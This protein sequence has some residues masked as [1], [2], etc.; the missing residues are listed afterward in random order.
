MHENVSNLLIETGNII[1]K[2]LLL[3][4]FSNLFSPKQLWKNSHITIVSLKP[5]RG[6]VNTYLA[7]TIHLL[8][9]LYPLSSIVQQASLSYH[10]RSFVL[11]THISQSDENNK[12]S[13]CNCRAG[14]S[15]SSVKVVPYYMVLRAGLIC[16]VVLPRCYLF[17]RTCDDIRRLNVFG[18]FCCANIC[19]LIKVGLYLKVF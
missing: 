1:G 14:E 5:W 12:L 16:F 18:Y 17:I 9:L 2:Y 15:V 10:L 6:C 8:T 11:S 13:I 4:A 3:T 19:W 7:T